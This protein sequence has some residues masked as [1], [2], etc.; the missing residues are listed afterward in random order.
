MG[1]GIERKA[2]GYTV[3]RREAVL[4]KMLP[5]NNKTIAEL[6]REEGIL[7]CFITGATAGKLDF[8]GI[9]PHVA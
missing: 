2:M 7:Q 9:N 1:G 6:A 4:K 3:E 5:P 8:R